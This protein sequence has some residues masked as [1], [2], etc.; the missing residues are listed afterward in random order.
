MIPLIT[1]N[2]KEG[3]WRQPDLWCRE[4]IEVL[5]YDEIHVTFEMRSNEMQIKLSK[6]HK[7][8][9]VIDKSID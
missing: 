6:N 4:T 3:R 7:V 1:V 9:T 5:Q 2:S 8:K